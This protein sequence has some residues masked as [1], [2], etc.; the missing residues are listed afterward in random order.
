MVREKI[1]SVIG[2]IRPMLQM[3]GG[4]VELVNVDEAA[5]IVEVRLT[6]ACHG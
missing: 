6:G 1:E 5:G 4:D 2:E 3:D